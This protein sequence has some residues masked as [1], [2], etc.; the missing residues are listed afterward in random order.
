MDIVTLKKINDKNLEYAM[1]NVNSAENEV[2]VASSWLLKQFAPQ[3]YEATRI[4][5]QYARLL[6]KSYL[7]EQEAIAL[8]EKNKNTEAITLFNKAADLRLYISQEKLTASENLP[9]ISELQTIVK[10]LKIRQEGKKTRKYK[11]SKASS[12]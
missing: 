4:D 5:S 11:K 7:I 9:Y 3:L 2:K 8:L 12:K 6:H 10:K 1:N